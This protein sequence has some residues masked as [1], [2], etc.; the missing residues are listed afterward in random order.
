MPHCTYGP[1]ARRRSGSGCR[2]R[3]SLAPVGAGGGRADVVLGGVRV[4][5]AVVDVGRHAVAVHVEQLAV[6]EQSVVREHAR[7][8]RVEPVVRVVG[9]QHPRVRVGH[10]ESEAGLVLAEAQRLR[11]VDL[12]TDVEQRTRR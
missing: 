9:D 11:P 5:R 2:P 4:V 1:Q 12:E 8:S 7:P 3:R 10:A 6:D